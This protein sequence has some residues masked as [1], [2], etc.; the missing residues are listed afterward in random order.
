[1]ELLI[2]GVVAVLTAYAAFA[3]L[4]LVVGRGVDIWFRVAGW[5]GTR[6]E[7]RSAA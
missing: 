2:G 1:M 7:A 3:V 6:R 5:W 4:A